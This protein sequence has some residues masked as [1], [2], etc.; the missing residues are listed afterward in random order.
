VLT[1]ISARARFVT[2]HPAV[3]RDHRPPHHGHCT[4]PLAAQI[5]VLLSDVLDAIDP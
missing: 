1:I 5:T 3:P 2:A 4:L